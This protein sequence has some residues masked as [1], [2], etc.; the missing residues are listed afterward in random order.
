VGKISLNIALLSDLLAHRTLTGIET[1][2]YQIAHSLSLS[3]QIHLTLYSRCDIPEHRIPRGA[4]LQKIETFNYLKWPL[5]LSILQNRKQL[6][7]FDLIHCP[8]VIV[9]PSVLLYKKYKIIMTVHDLVPALF[10]EHSNYKKFLYYKYILKFVFPFIDH[11]I[12]PSRSVRH[13][14]SRHYNIRP[15]R[16]S[17]IYEGVSNAFHQ[18]PRQKKDYILTVSTVEPRKNFRRVIDA[19]INLKTNHCIPHKLYIVGK[20]GWSCDEIY[21]IPKEF[22]KSIVFTG[23]IPQSELID[24]YQNAKLFVYPSLHEGFGL[25]VVEAMAC[26]CPVVTSNLSSLPE[27]AGDAALFV[28][29][30]RVD[31][32]ASSILKILRNENLASNLVS[33]GLERAKQYT[34]ARCAQNTINVYKAVLTR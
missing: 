30:Y 24:L 19:F 18:G 14:L 3:K 27:I 8:T 12:V 17:V 13:S 9:P 21:R 29:P 25:P 11:F 16:I 33:K 1:Y 22:E 28:D 4:T 23:Y 32:I 31:D 26:G 20:K 6:A 15:G 2:L 7:R 34:W 5:P 10:P